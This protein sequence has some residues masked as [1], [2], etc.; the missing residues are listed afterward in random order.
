M[1]S[2]ELMGSSW[3]KEG[4]DGR[5]EHISFYKSTRFGQDRKILQDKTYHKGKASFKLKKEDSLALRMKLEI[6]I[7]TFSL[8]S[9]KSSFFSND[10]IEMLQKKS[11]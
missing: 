11:Q 7:L 2:G 1:G 3:N 10:K 4:K 5:Q 9:L 8:F 6:Q